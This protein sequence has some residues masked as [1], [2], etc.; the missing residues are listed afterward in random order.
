MWITP[1]L[2]S[3]GHDPAND[4]AAALTTSD[5]WVHNAI[6]KIMQS[7]A[8]KAGGVIFLTWDEA[9]NRTASGADKIPMIIISP[10][11]KSAGY[12]SNTAYS[13][14]SYLA[15]VEDLLGLPRLATVAQEP[16]MLE[17]LQ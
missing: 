17:F 10:R 13:H 15:T 9:E 16:N 12:K 3:D 6:D 2:L 5:T 14:K 7:A 1:N 8:Y 4:P 11:I